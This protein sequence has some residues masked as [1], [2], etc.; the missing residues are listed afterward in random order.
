MPNRFRN[1]DMR[2]N[3]DCAVEN[4]RNGSNLLFYKG[5]RHRGNAWATTFWWGFD[6][7]A[8]ERWDSK[9]RKMT[10]WAWYRAG[11]DMA[12]EENKI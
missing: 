7:V 8:R 1:K 9:S 4:Y 6:G 12:K 10:S 2:A 3:Y 5:N 11:E